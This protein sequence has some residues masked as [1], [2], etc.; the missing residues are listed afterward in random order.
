LQ[1]GQL[2]QRAAV[3]VVHVVAARGRK[4]IRVFFPGSDPAP[5]A[6]AAVRTIV[7]HAVRAAP[8]MKPRF[9]FIVST[10]CCAVRSRAH[11]AAPVGLA[12]TCTRAANASGA[13]LRTKASNGRSSSTSAHTAPVPGTPDCTYISG[14]PAA[15]PG[16]GARPCTPG[17]VTESV[18]FVGR[19]WGDARHTRKSNGGRLVRKR[20]RKRW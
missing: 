19:T 11:R 12:T 20:P 2:G 1:P 17:A 18:A 3:G 5:H 9:C 14:A 13:A 4:R 10:P 15:A 8:I 6:F 7:A 16:A